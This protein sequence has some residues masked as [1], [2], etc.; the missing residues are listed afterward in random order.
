MIKGP[1]GGILIATTLESPLI[2]NAIDKQIHLINVDLYKFHPDDDII[3]DCNGT[4]I[5]ENSKVF[6]DSHMIYLSDSAQLIVRGD[7]EFLE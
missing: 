3:I 5:L 4:I 1:S 7:T 2:V 6:T